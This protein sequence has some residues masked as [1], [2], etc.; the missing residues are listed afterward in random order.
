MRRSR[1]GNVGLRAAEQLNGHAHGGFGVGDLL[2]TPSDIVLPALDF[3]LELRDERIALL[4]A[5]FVIGA[6]RFQRHGRCNQADG[7][8][9]RQRKQREKL[10]RKRHGIPCQNAAR[11]GDR[12]STPRRI[13]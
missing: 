7:C 12:P 10:G 6:A 4:A 8:Q 13:L 11:T 2:H 5:A 9:K 3:A 1:N